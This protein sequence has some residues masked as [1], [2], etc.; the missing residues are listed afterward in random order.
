MVETYKHSHTHKNE[1]NHAQKTKTNIGQTR[2]S[3]ER[4]IQKKEVQGI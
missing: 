1:N 3:K 2:D 4:G